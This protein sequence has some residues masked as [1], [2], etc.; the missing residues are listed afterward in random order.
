MKYVFYISVLIFSLQLA[1][2]TQLQPQLTSSVNRVEE[3]IKLAQNLVQAFPNKQA[4]TYINQAKRLVRE[5]TNSPVDKSNAAMKQQQL[6][7]AHKYAQQA[8]NLLSTIPAKRIRNDVEEL[9]RQAEQIVPGKLNKNAER[10]L[11]R[12]KS[13]QQQANQALTNGDYLKA[14]EHLRIAQFL[15]ERSMT[16]V[17]DQKGNI[18]EQLL[19]E[20][21]RFN[22]LLQKARRSVATCQ[23]PNAKKLLSEA[24]KQ[25]RNIAQAA[26]N[27]NYKFA[28]NLYYNA[29]RL[30][31]RAIEICQ[32]RRI[33]QVEIALE[34]LELF[35]DTLSSVQQNADKTQT[36]KQKMILRRAENLH[37]QAR[38]SYQKRHYTITIRKL[39]IANNILR[40][41]FDEEPS[42][43]LANRAGNELSRLKFEIE[44]IEDNNN[45]LS[46]RGHKALLRA[47]K[48]SVAD[49]ERFLK[50]G[51]IRL[52]L[53]SILAGNR[54]LTAL[55]S[56]Q[57]REANIS[58]Q[59][60]K[61]RLDRL[62]EEI[63]QINENQGERDQEIISAAQKML[64]RANEAAENGHFELANEYIK[65]GFD[66]V[67]KVK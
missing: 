30:L 54:F 4:I 23:N 14:T 7:M 38:Q 33:P 46:K 27:R 20:K 6:S 5:A 64:S 45:F 21:N 47:A 1:A 3:Q 63:E 9:I 41:I 15:V 17:S 24:N 62:N 37:E 19:I 28:L 25:R 26:N 48:K 31:L 10:L 12:A 55:E 22:D 18:N 66:L 49:A 8:V 36:A 61:I 35:K 39:Q 67:G 59:D 51:R 43:T 2:Q 13:N 44:K 65:T 56:R 50:L 34:E 29:S 53:D 32:G 42:Q 52:A 58:E 57:R 40:R 60:L 16:L 11:N